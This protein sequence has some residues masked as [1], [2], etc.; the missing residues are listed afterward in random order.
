MT[1]TSK[2]KKKPINRPICADQYFGDWLIRRKQLID[3]VSAYRAG[4][5]P[6]NAETGAE[7][8]GVLN[9]QRSGRIAIIP[10]HGVMLKGDSSFAGTTSTVRIRRAIRA[11]IADKTID[12]IMLSIDS[13]GGTVS[14]AFDLADDIASASGVKP[15]HAHVEDM[16]ASAAYLAASQAS[17]ISA[18]RTSMIGSLGVVTSLVDETG[19]LEKAGLKVHA[20]A[21]SDSK[22]AGH[23]GAVTPEMIEEAQRIVN[24]VNEHFIMAVRNGRGIT[25]SQSR[26]LFD[27]PGGE[28]VLAND[29]QRSGMIDSVSS[30]DEAVSKL[31]K[32]AFDMDTE[33]FAAFAA[34]NPD[35]LRAAASQM[36]DAS[37]EETSAKAMAQERERCVCIASM[38]DDPKVVR[39]HLQAGSD[40]SVVRNE[41]FEMQKTELSVLRE[42]VKSNAGV[43]IAQTGVVVDMH[44]DP[45][46]PLEN[47]PDGEKDPKALAEWEYDNKQVMF[48]AKDRA[49]YVK[50]RVAALTGT[51]SLVG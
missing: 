14:G 4:E 11:A 26:K 8:E 21:S 24:D 37:C 29:A 35:A 34:K 5:L 13:P 15:V 16:A 3:L 48:T 30:L 6:V 39:E 28:V 19:R 38:S 40:P 25:D 41:L 46:D 1:K 23:D 18:T 31:A 49:A 17:T 9:I 22:A 10:I 2:S 42:K 33:R 20:V 43:S 47:V 36:I 51:M 45:P 44:G 32:E 50:S 7:R 12:A 27:E